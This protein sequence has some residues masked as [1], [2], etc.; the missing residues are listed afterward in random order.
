MT[1]TT[2][3]EEVFK[4]TGI[5]KS[6]GAVHVLKD[7]SFSVLKGEIHALMGENGAGK[8]TL[9]N[10][11]SGILSKD[12]GEITFCNEKVEHMDADKAKTL[13]IAFVRQELNL[14]EHLSVAENIYMGRLPYK[15]KVLGIIDF[16]KLHHD[17]EA[18]LTKLGAKFKATDRVEKL[19]TANK[20]LVEIAKSISLDAKV[21]IFDEPTTSLSD[22]DVENLFKIIRTLKTDGVSSVYISHRMKEIYELCDRI[23][24]LRDG[25]YIGT[26]IIKEITS[27]QIIKMLV[28]RALTD[29][30]PKEEVP[31]GD[32][33]I[34]VTNLTDKQNKVKEI[35]FQAKKGEIVGF[36][37][38]V[39]AGRTEL[40]E[41]LFG[42]KRA[43]SGEIKIDGTPVK[44][45]N[46]VDAV[47]AGICLLTEDRKNLGLALPLSIEDNINITSID[48]I[49][50]NYKR[51]KD[52]SDK[53]INSL[54]IKVSDAKLP[55]KSLSGGNQQKV[56]L[57]KWLNTSSKIFIFDEPTKGIDVGAKSEIYAIMASLAKEKNTILIVSS[58]IP[59]LL[60][61]CDRIYVI[62]EGR[63]SG[64]LTRENA[65]QEKIIEFAT[66]GGQANETKYA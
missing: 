19:S 47:H 17:S 9:M 13:G 28:G 1:T 32:V 8:S 56:V 49:R 54:K 46:P 38:L 41:L 25:T 3:T 51:M 45:K 61:V 63:I 5:Y 2:N 12:K 37:G 60:G 52:T 31:L 18:I 35:S 55:V 11:L 39:G 21:I 14:A 23:T 43:K 24:I 15:N 53:Y 22:K 64:E 66:I 34:E 58:E 26:E 59:E 20:Q 6:F 57:A 10:I 4:M 50:L 44:I 29:L 7:V 48:T 40:V 30:Y 33:S 42:V 62:C 27:E 16:K 65:T 36:A